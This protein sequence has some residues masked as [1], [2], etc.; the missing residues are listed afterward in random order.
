MWWGVLHVRIAEIQT[1]LG[2]ERKK[3]SEIQCAFLKRYSKEKDH[4]KA[5]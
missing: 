2:A 1:S 3:T 5:G 4:E